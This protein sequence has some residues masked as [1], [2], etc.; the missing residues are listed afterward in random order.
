MSLIE[1]EQVE[2]IAIVGA[3]TIGGGWTAHYLAQGKSVTVSDPAP[4]AESRL[5]AFIDKAW[6]A[7]QKLGVA[8]GSDPT[9]MRFEA[10]P[11]KAVREAQFVQ[12]SAPE[13]VATKV[14][15]YRQIESA[16]PRDAV[17][18]TSTSGLSI[19]EL[20]E[21][22]LGP[23]RYVVG[24]PVNPPHLI[25]LVE[26]IG[27]RQTDPAV[28]DWTLGFYR[29]HGKRAIHIR[30]EVPGHLVNRLQVALWR[31]AVHAVAAGIASVEDVDAAVVHA[32]GLR[33]AMVGPHLTIHLAGGPG[34][35]RHHLE[36]LGPAIEDWWADLG[37]PRL[38]DEVKAKL[39]EGMDEATAGATF[40]QIVSRRDNLLV[41][42]LEMRKN[43]MSAEA[44][45]TDDGATP[46]TN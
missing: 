19:S 18:A 41:A 46:C 25:P 22:R 2:R 14:S 1:P 28:V 27:G 17:V 29:A 33:W 37:S 16:L 4:N 26:V 43:E 7:I 20:Q 42:F 38:T 32:L 8:P 21:G 39:I 6:P 24:H 12:E 13:D 15:L 35:M 31:E 44:D 9:A 34:G 30:R 36:H 11:A 5:R 10:D 45:S 23:K 40:D 3:G